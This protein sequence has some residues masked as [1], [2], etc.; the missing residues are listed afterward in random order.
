MIAADSAVRYS[1]CV[2]LEPGGTPRFIYTVAAVA[3]SDR[4]EITVLYD[5]GEGKDEEEVVGLARTFEETL[6]W[7]Y[8]SGDVCVVDGVWEVEGC[9]RT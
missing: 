8:G 5:V 1:L 6:L 4:G 7:Y 9:A 3:V 2:P